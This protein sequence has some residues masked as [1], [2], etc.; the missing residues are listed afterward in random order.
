MGWAISPRPDAGLTDGSLLAA[1]A[2]LQPGQRPF[3]HSDGG[4]HYF[5][6]GWRR[7]CEERGIARSM[8][9]KGT[10]PDNAACLC[11]A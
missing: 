3:C 2:Q 8:S 7:I 10:S 1:C 4:I 9:R 6:P 5:W 11:A